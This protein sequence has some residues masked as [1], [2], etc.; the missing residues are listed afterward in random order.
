MFCKLAV[1]TM[2]VYGYGFVV[3]KVVALEDLDL[4]QVSRSRQGR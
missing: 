3:C 2:I 4:M 1:V